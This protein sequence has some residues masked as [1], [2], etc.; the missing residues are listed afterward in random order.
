MKITFT[1]KK[2]VAEV[3][4]SSAC[5]A[6]EDC[7]GATAMWSLTEELVGIFKK[8]LTAADPNGYSAI[9]AKRGANM[10][11]TFTGSSYTQIDEFV[12]VYEGPK[13]GFLMQNLGPR[14]GE[15]EV[16]V[17]EG[18]FGKV[19]GS[20]SWDADDFSTGSRWSS[21]QETIGKQ[22]IEPYAELRGQY[23]DLAERVAKL[24][25]QGKIKEADALL[26]GA[27]PSD[28]CPPPFREKFCSG[29][30]RRRFSTADLM[31]C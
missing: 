8:S 28:I 27:S 6:I 7:S 15:V 13:N 22:F 10:F 30:G 21:Y 3:V 25:G 16:T 5:P 23:G 31:N 4:V 11:E 19:V 2:T 14:W 12:W 24:K 18:T 29:R 20:A 1:T 9:K 26:A 17:F